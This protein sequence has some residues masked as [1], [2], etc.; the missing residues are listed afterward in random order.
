MS[1]SGRAFAWCGRPGSGSPSLHCALFLK[2]GSHVTHTSLALSL[3][4][5][6]GRSLPV[7]LGFTARAMELYIGMRHHTRLLQCWGSNKPRASSILAKQSATKLCPQLCFA[8]LSADNPCSPQTALP[9]PNGSYCHQLL[10]L[11]LTPASA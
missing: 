6:Q 10:R 7:F 9:E 3:W 8:L 1:L 2:T 5:E 11:V 4:H